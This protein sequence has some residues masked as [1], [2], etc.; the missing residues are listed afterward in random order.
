MVWSDA[1]DD[2]VREFYPRHGGSWAGWAEVL[3]GRTKAAIRVRAGRIGVTTTE[4]KG[5][6]RPRRDPYDTA[7]TRG[8][9]EGRTPAEIDAERHWTPGTAKRVL[10][11][12]WAKGERVARK[13]A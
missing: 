8:M 1:E 3:P 4:A 11:G 12:M 2:A 9:S 13:G 6:A 5:V 10:M 7:V